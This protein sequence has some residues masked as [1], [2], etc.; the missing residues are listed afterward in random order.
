MLAIFIWC[1]ICKLKE[2]AGLESLAGYLLKMAVHVL[3]IYWNYG[4]SSALQSLM[5]S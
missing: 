4:L 2:A 3:E 5:P 1:C